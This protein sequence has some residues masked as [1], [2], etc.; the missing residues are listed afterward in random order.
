MK[1]S[2]FQGGFTTEAASAL[3]VRDPQTFVLLTDKS[4]IRRDASFSRW[5]IHEVVRQYALKRLQKRMGIRDERCPCGLYARFLHD[6]LKGIKGRDQQATWMKLK[7]TSQTSKRLGIGLWIVGSWNGWTSCSRACTG[8]AGLLYMQEFHHMMRR[9][10]QALDAPN[11]S[12]VFTLLQIL[13]RPRRNRRDTNEQSA[14]DMLRD[15]RPELASIAYLHVG[16]R[17]QYVLEYREAIAWYEH[18]LH[19]GSRIGDVFYIGRAQFDGDELRL[20]Q[21]DGGGIFA[22]STG[23]R[24]QPEDWRFAE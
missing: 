24:K 15:V 20:P 3:A 21:C 13:S 17:H 16:R 23:S 9:A 19:I 1:L 22:L 18:A 11:D 14:L 2:V 6:R 12:P 4:L 8:F 10:R 7:P 5:T